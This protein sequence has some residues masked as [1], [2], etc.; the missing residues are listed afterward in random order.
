MELSEKEFF[1]ENGY[2]ILRKFFKP[3]LFDE[4][5]AEIT[6]IGKFIVGDKFAFDSYHPELITPEKQSQLYDRLHYLPC[7][8]RLSGNLDLLAA[9]RELGLQLPVLMGCCN[10][11]YDRPH[12]IRHLFDWHQ[13]TLYLLGSVNAVTAWIPFSRVD[14]IHGTVQL[15]PGSHKAGILPYKK[16]SDKP[17]EEQR[18]FLQRDLAID[19]DITTAPVTV[20]ADPGDVLIFKQMAV[21]RSMANLSDKARWTAQIR[22]SDL[23]SSGFLEEGCPT[24]DK[25]NIFFQKYPGFVHPLSTRH[26]N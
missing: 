22:I 25:E 23:T 13:D 1:D 10:M 21:H 6:Q 14:D 26:E 9:C 2:I 15:I 7:L 17:V 4:V 24:G 18:Q 16:I 11:R 5:K 12:D 3:E 20:S 19:T 8:S